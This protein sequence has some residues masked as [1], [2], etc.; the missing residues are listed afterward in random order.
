MH[1]FTAV[2]VV[3]GWT[4]TTPYRAA[5]WT[6]SCEVWRVFRLNTGMAAEFM[7]KYQQVV[8]YP[9]CVDGSMWER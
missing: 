1:C 3:G 9:A 4:M 5:L 7:S 6:F 8:Q 2:C